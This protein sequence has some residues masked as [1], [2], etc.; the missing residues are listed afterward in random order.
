M[1]KVR[2]DHKSDKTNKHGEMVKAGALLL[3]FWICV[4]SLGCGCF[5]K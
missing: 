3:F 4:M 5:V 2:C 1:C